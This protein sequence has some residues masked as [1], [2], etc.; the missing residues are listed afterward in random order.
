MVSDVNLHPY[1]QAWGGYIYVLDG[2]NKCVRKVTVPA[3]EVSTAVG[4]CGGGGYVD[5]K[6]SFAQT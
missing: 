1:T 2:L 5:G 4:H 3:G 6:D